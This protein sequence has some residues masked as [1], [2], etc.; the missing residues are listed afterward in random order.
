MYTLD[1]THKSASKPPILR[2]TAAQAMLIRWFCSSNT[3]LFPVVAPGFA[4]PVINCP[5]AKDGLNFPAFA[6]CYSCQTYF[7]T[8]L[9]SFSFFSFKLSAS[10]RA[11]CFC[12]LSLFFYHLCLPFLPP[13][14]VL[15]ERRV[16]VSPWHLL[17][18]AIREYCTYTPYRFI[19]LVRRLPDI[20]K[21][22]SPFRNDKHRSFLR[23]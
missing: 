2:L 21:M 14:M 15:A 19:N 9:D 1:R 23:I 22:F 7:V 16:I 6:V 5:P 11:F 3:S 13:D 20:Q 10:L 12:R 17:T 18:K 8:P 4:T